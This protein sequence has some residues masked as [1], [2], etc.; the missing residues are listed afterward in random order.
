MT[1]A[2]AS[3]RLVESVGPIVVKEVRQG[4]RARVFAIF[5]GV[6]LTACLAL[7]FFSFARAESMD[8]SGRYAFGSFLTAL[9]GV[10]F[11]VIP[12]LA[13]RSMAREVEDE[14]WVLLSLT[15]LGAHAITRG[16][17]L[18]A[19]SQAFLFGSA[20]APFVLFSYF[21][22][23]IDLLRI[24]VALT[25]SMTWSAFLTALAVAIAT[26]A[27]SKLGRTIALFVI[28]ALLGLG[29][30]AGVAFGWVLARE[31]QRLTYVEGLRNFTLGLGLFSSALTPLLLEGAASGLALPSENA[32]RG[33]RLW[34]AGVTVLA[35]VFG[36]VAFV[37]SDGNRTDATA[38][39]VITCF[40]LCLAGVFCISERDGWPRQTSSQGHFR[41][42]ALRSF[43]LVLGLLLL[44]TVVWGV[45]IANSTRGSLGGSGREVRGWL[46]A[47]TYPVLYLSLAVV[48]G[49]GTP[50]RRLG[51]PVA[52]RV[53]FLGSVVVGVVLSAALSAVVD[54]RPTGKTM[55]ALNPL[56]GLI[57]QL[58][59][60]S[61]ELENLLAFAIVA[62]SSMA[63]AALA[64]LHLRD[65][66]RT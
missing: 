64:M 62:A 9:G 3:E 22:N 43:L 12:F 29:T 35:L 5:F 14:T 34:L 61:S 66:V 2:T 53:A 57:N 10:C 1:I 58:E 40:F 55:N 39:Q 42:G 54:G 37:T 63:V 7:A 60:G 23:G 15:G 19:M 59:S 31:G 51:E 65:E 27:H 21:L 16:K 32:S 4:L 6:L 33:P 20:C 46:A 45:M 48:M 17:W 41:P 8:D 47:A 38:G 49:R 50:L 13:F 30:F 11:F 24:G 26:Q 18:S 56:V 36:G 52:T 44:S 28:I 25:L